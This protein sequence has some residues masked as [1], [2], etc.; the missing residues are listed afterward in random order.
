MPEW[1]VCMFAP[2]TRGC[3]HPYRRRSGPEHVRP[4]HTGMSRVV[5]Y[6]RHQLRDPPRALGDAPD[7]AIL[8]QRNASAPRSRGCALLDLRLGRPHQTRPAHSGTPPPRPGGHCL[9]L[10]RRGPPGARALRARRRRTTSL[11]A[12][13]V[14]PANPDGPADPD[15]PD[16][17]DDLAGTLSAVF[18]A[19]RWL[20]A[21]AAAALVAAA[22]VEPMALAAPATLLTLPA[23][24]HWHARGRLAAVDRRLTH[25]AA[26]AA[27][28]AAGMAAGLYAT[29]RHY[30]TLRSL[31]EWGLAVTV[32]AMGTALLVSVF[33]TLD[34]MQGGF[35]A[36][37]AAIAVWAAM[38][39]G[40][41][42][43]MTTLFV[44]AESVAARTAAVVFCGNTAAALWGLCMLAPRPTRRPRPAQQPAAPQ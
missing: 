41:V 21:A 6:Q 11:T 18:P 35:E 40:I 14:M 3:A 28:Q 34:D 20:A 1:S 10:P 9:I 32:A 25:P 29:A 22:V 39:C 23:L 43:L 19:W 2:R 7:A 4:A 15:G 36:A 12:V 27:A 5:D 42:A 8:R 17:P 24:K 30:D 33:R 13:T 37:R 16:G 31:W 26:F 44:P 38:A